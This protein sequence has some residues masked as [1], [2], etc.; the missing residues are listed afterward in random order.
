MI[1]SFVYEMM[2]VD[3]K[4]IVRTADGINIYQWSNDKMTEM[5]IVDKYTD[6]V[7]FAYSKFKKIIIFA[8][9]NGD[10]RIN[11]EQQSFRY[12]TDRT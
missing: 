7:A 6:V 11:E 10:F 8:T 9:K 12:S 1:P 5:E 3:Q 4:I 2:A